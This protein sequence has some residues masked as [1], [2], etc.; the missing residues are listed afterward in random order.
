MGKRF[1]HIRTVED[2]ATAD[3]IITEVKNIYGDNPNW[4]I[5]ETKKEKISGGRIQVTIE[6]TKLELEEKETKNMG[7]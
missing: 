2:E 3:R 6:L 5:G 7:L 4:K 1:D